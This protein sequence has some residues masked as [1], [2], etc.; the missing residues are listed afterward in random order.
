MK[1]VKT[2]ILRAPGTNCDFETMV[3]FETAGAEVDSALVYELFRR[4]KRLS[5]YRIMVI[6]GGFTYGD[7]ISAGKIMANEIRLR[8][9]EDIRKFI[10]AGRLVL[11]ICNGFQVLVKTGIL[12]G[13]SVPGAQPVTL[14]N[15]DSGKFEC[16]WI[17]LKVNEKSPCV[18]TRGMRG[19]YIPVAH[20]EGKLV[21]GPGIV[22]KLNIVVQYADASGNTGTGY[23]D[24]PNGS[25][26][27]IAGICDDSGRVFAL[28][29]HPERFI[30][31]TQ[32]PR[33]TREPPREG[34]GLRVF[35]NAL[36]WANNI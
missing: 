3:A 17:H 27:D 21:A 18:F 10:D 24:N 2:L 29:P 14:T 19:M 1:K 30:R 20:G 32:Y 33:W 7:D 22:D 11:G 31:W 35:V 23:P 12:P 28:M 25:E 8:L 26:K 16:R 36:E 9:G 5:D 15:N 4:E 13:P 6:P 34:D